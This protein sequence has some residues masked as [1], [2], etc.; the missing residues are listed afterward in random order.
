[1]FIKLPSCSYEPKRSIS[2]LSERVMA[3][4]EAYAKTYLGGF[5]QYIPEKRR[6]KKRPVFPCE[7][8]FKGHAIIARARGGSL[9][10]RLP[11]IYMLVEC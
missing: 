3:D 9:G 10:T 5:G 2:H 7:C 11:D 4:A 1:M 8:E 6:T